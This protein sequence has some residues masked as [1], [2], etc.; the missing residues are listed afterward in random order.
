MFEEAKR[1]QRDWAIQQHHIRRSLVVQNNNSNDFYYNN[2]LPPPPQQQQTEDV[3]FNQQQSVYSNTDVSSMQ[4]NRPSITSLVASTNIV[5]P[6]LMLNEQHSHHGDTSKSSSSIKHHRSK[7]EYYVTPLNET[8][9]NDVT[10]SS[11]LPNTPLITPPDLNNDVRLNSNFSSELD[12]PHDSDR[13]S[14]RSDIVSNTV[15]EEE[16]K[17]PRDNRRQ[18]V[19]RMIFGQ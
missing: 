9:N 11:S 2:S 8:N 10:P 6:S 1:R 18:S 4:L 19:K 15:V 14:I 17:S 5:D 13:F 3:A 12:F 16:K 7:E